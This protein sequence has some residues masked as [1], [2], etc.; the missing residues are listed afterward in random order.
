MFWKKKSEAYTILENKFEGYTFTGFFRFEERDSSGSKE[1]L[2]TK[3][4][5]DNLTEKELTKFKKV[6]HESI[7]L[8]SSKGLSDMLL[9]TATNNSDVTSEQRAMAENDI[10]ERKQRLV[11]LNEFL[12]AL[13]AGGLREKVSDEKGV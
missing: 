1:Y 11:Y 3:S 2:P 5:L 12:E 7:E 6:I 8:N 10:K 4:D 13:E 9:E